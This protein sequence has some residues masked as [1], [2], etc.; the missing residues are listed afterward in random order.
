MNEIPRCVEGQ[1]IGI[2]QPNPTE[3]WECSCAVCGS[4]DL[5]A[6]KRA[7]IIRAEAQR[8]RAEKILTSV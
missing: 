7:S 3:D 1:A 2:K 4:Q 6:T 8:G 5:L